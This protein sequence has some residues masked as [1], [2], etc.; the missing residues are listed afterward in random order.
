MLRLRFYKT[1]KFHNGVY[2][3]IIKNTQIVLIKKKKTIS[4]IVQNEYS[5]HE[6]HI[7]SVKKT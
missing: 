4:H 3:N 2:Q 7:Y 6:Y 5:F 1:S